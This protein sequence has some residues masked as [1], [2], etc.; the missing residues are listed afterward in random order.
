MMEITI[1]V[2]LFIV[3]LLFLVVPLSMGIIVKTPRQIQ[4]FGL[5]LTCFGG[6]CLL[7]FPDDRLIG[8]L[9][10]LLGLIVGTLGFAK[11]ER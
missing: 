2:S 4:Y 6:V 9:V 1:T 5:L 3:A 8:F 7:A 10:A 11:R